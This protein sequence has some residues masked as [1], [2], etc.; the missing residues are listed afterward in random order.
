MCPG[1]GEKLLLMGSRRALMGKPGARDGQEMWG[2]T[3]PGRGTEL[4]VL[5]W[6]KE[7]P[8][9]VRVLCFALHWW[10]MILHFNRVGWMHAQWRWGQRW[11]RVPQSSCPSARICGP[12]AAGLPAASPSSAVSHKWYKRKHRPW[13]EPWEAIPK[14]AQEGKNWG[15]S[16]R[17]PA[18][19]VPSHP[20]LVWPPATSQASQLPPAPGSSCYLL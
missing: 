6:R 11:I 1:E 16:L 14:A 2:D 8:P 7:S 18:P 17:A 15:G 5:S 4:S 10:Q 19:P 3:L 13:A 12:N 9:A 20:A